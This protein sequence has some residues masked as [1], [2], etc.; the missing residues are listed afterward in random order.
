M[1][2]K[3]DTIATTNRIDNQ[4][5][6]AMMR[7]VV[8]ALLPAVLTL[9]WFFGWGIVSNLVLAVGF[10]VL[11]ET[12]ML[13]L[14]KRPIIPF[15]SDYSAVVTGALLGLALP[16]ASPWWLIFIAVFFAIVIA[17]HLYGGLG[18]N[19]FNPAMIGYAVVLVSFPVEMT[20]WLAPM[21][22]SLAVSNLGD[23]F[24]RVFSLSSIPAW[25]GVT[26][27]TPLD[28]VKT[29][30][31]QDISLTQSMHEGAQFGFV[32][33]KAWEWVS[34][35]Y[36]AG[37]LW[38]LYQKV[39]TW[40]IPVAFLLSLS[41]IASFFWLIDANTYASPLFHLLSGATMLGAFFIATDPISASTT[42]MGKLLYAAGIA[43]FIYI[44][45]IWGA[46]PDAVAFAV[47]IM[48]MA[49]PMIDHYTQPKIF[50]E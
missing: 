8:Y 43:L 42:P 48:N 31:T 22:L 21:E 35:A 12:L 9:F 4:H 50:G 11:L 20:R 41:V 18:Y 15:L 40:H 10:A 26:M 14:R 25:D 28:Y 37:G 38:L 5:I 19:P 3:T 2:F 33:G 34:L 39:I 17:K 27:A 30:L 36:L 13:T 29:N 45:R 1:E 49:A 23:T 44:I 47:I 46:Y 7:Q 24:S 32:A 16:S 6:A